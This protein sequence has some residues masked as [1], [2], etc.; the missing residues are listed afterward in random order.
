MPI[1]KLGTKQ[2]KMNLGERMT[3]S[4]LDGMVGTH[5]EFLILPLGRKVWERVGDPGPVPRCGLEV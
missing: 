5:F 4:S 2:G 3:S 1:L